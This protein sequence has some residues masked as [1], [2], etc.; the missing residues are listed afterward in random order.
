MSFKCF[1]RSKFPT[2]SSVSPLDSLKHS[3]PSDMGSS[4]TAHLATP[5]ETHMDDGISSASNLILPAWQG[6]QWNAEV[7]FKYETTTKGWETK[8]IDKELKKYSSP[9][10]HNVSHSAT[11]RTQPV[12]AWEL[13]ETL[14]MKKTNKQHF[15]KKWSIHTSKMYVKLLQRTLWTVR[16]TQRIRTQRRVCS[17]THKK[18]LAARIVFFLSY[19]I[20]GW[21]RHRSETGRSVRSSSP[22][23]K[24]QQNFA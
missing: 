11:S 5:R 15:L 13:L 3:Q 17:I 24:S 14:L 21:H 20:W 16:I 22:A 6:M 7:T 10:Q 18:Y 9:A 23:S 4:R 2:R 1:S 19:S 8:S 12:L